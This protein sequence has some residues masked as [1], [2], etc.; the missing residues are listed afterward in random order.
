MQ[1]KSGKRATAP[2][3]EWSSFQQIASYSNLTR[4]LRAFSVAD[5]AD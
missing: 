4:H 3:T 2:V 5:Q 1:K